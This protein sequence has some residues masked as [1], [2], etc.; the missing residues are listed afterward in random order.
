MAGDS[1]SDLFA[2]PGADEIRRWEAEHKRMGDAIKELQAKRLYLERLI[3]A[4]KG[5]SSPAPIGAPKRVDG[6]LKPGTWMHAVAEVVLLHPEG[7]SYDDLRER[8][9]GEL[10]KMVRDNPSTKGFY[11]AL[12]RLERDEIIVRHRNHAFTPAGFKRYT[13]KVERGEVDPVTGNDYRHSP[14][15]DAIKA[16]IREQGPAKAAALRQHLASMPQFRESMRNHSAIYNVLKRLVERE[17]LFHDEQASTFAL[18]ERNEAPP[19]STSGASE[20]GEAATS[21]SDTS[22]LFRVVK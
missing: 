10:G 14:M 20:P 4:A 21:L 5:E 6:K 1:F 3:A 2:L 18:M 19:G 12:R 8:M 22:S 13:D 11:G 15:A 9:T 16:Y 17:E 7:I